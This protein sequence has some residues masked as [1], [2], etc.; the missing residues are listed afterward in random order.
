MHNTQPTS[1]PL[2]GDDSACTPD[3]FPDA[4][5]SPRWVPAMKHSGRA[6]AWYHTG[7]D[8]L[9]RHCGHPTALRPYYI[10][11]LLAELGTFRQLRDAQAAALHHHAVTRAATYAAM[12]SESKQ[13]ADSELSR[14][15]QDVIAAAAE[16]ATMTGAA[17]W[18]RAFL[19]GIHL[20]LESGDR[21]EAAESWFFNRTEY[22]R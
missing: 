20:V 2:R 11:G 14:E 7:A 1:I 8:M 17:D 12:L 19:A 3:L 21:S 13:I 5:P 16:H 9:V 4:E 6:W 22:A 10:D 18:G 15:I